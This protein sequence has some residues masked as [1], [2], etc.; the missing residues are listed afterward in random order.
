MISVC[1]ELTDNVE[2]N[3]TQIASSFEYYSLTI[4]ESTDVSDTAQLAIFVCRINVNFNITK[5][6]LS[7]QE[8]KNTTTGYFS[9][10]QKVDG[11]I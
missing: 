3:L 9:K 5:D 4:D 8:M 2:L 11:K 7:L 6:M 1:P 10:T